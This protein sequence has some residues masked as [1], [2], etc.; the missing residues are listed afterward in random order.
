MIPAAR[1]QTLPETVAQQPPGSKA[2]SA[3]HG[4]QG[5]ENPS[6]TWYFQ[7]SLFSGKCLCFFSE[8][9]MF[10]DSEYKAGF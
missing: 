5:L 7:H 10:K 2:L 9:V 4:S 3:P 6:P 8:G 1:P